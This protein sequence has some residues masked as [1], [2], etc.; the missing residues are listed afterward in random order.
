MRI[1]TGLVLAL[2]ST[3]PA[4]A[5]SPSPPAAAKAQP[6]ADTPIADLIADPAAKAVLDRNVP[7]LTAHPA[8]EQ[9]KTMSLRQVQPMSGGQITEAALAKVD[10]ELKTLPAK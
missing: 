2:L 1:V 4:L 8:Y 6:S 9:I 10:A 3:A 5:Q 7:G